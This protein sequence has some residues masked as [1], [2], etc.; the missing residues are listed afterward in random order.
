[1]KLLD[2]YQQLMHY[3]FLRLGLLASFLSALSA[4]IVGVLLV[5]RRM[6][7]VGDSLSHALLPGVSIAFY[8]F[9]FSLPA[10][11]VGGLLSGLLVAFLSVILQNK[12]QLL[13]DSSFAVFF[14]MSMSFGI[15]LISERGSSTDLLHILFGSPLSLEPFSL[16]LLFITGAITLVG[17]F[18]GWRGFVAEFL[19]PHWFRAALGPAL[20]FQLLFLFLVV[21]N[22]VA[23]FYVTGTLLA[24]GQMLLPAIA[25]SLFASHLRWIFLLAGIFSF[26]TSAFGLLLS[27]YY[28]FPLGPVSVLASGLLCLIGWVSKKGLNRFR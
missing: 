2:F 22:L 27:F 11:F 26:F 20:F 24:V 6:S 14:L 19:Q 4:P 7:L 9:G 23:N 17:L 10:L 21:L 3:E 5:Y 13:E 25:A 16:L 8:F 15:L 28:D 18:L 12:T 1:M